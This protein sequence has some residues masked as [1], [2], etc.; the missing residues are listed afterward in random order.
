MS[1]S[2]VHVRRL[3]AE[4]PRPRDEQPKHHPQQVDVHVPRGAY[5]GELSD[6][7]CFG[8]AQRCF[9]RLAGAT[10]VHLRS[11]GVTVRTV[12]PGN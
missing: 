5:A 11:G 9:P 4:R 7:P 12:N 2:A 6:G 8:R 1:A 3:Q 10:A